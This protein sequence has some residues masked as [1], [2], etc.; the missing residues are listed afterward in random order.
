MVDD[1]ERKTRVRVKVNLESVEISE[2]PDSYRLD[3]SVYQRSYFP[4]QMPQSPREKRDQRVRFVED[5]VEDGAEGQGE[6][7][8]VAEMG[9]RMHVGSVTVPVPMVEGGEGERKREGK[10]KI[11]GLGRRAKEKEERLN[12]IGY[13]MSWSQS[14]TFAGK[15]VFLQ[16]SCELPLIF[17][18]PRL[19]HDQG[20]S[21]QARDTD[22]RTLAVDAYRNKVGSTMAAGGQE[23]ST[24]APHLETRIGKKMWVTRKDRRARGSKRADTP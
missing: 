12:D 14:R 13:R 22:G 23:V 17:P 16:K 11:P 7:L 1:T 9:R 15:V 5:D 20:V 4:T 3:N 21:D 2:L 8:G 18:Q 10:L 24:V 19:S 6:G